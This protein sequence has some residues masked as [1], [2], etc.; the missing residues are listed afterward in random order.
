M[1]LSAIELKIL[2]R[3]LVPKY[4][5]G[6][7]EETAKFNQRGDAVLDRC[8]ECVVTNPAK[9]EGA[10]AGIVGNSEQVI[11]F[12]ESANGAVFAFGETAGRAAALSCRKA[13]AG[14]ISSVTAR[15]RLRIS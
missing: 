6:A 9:S 5:L 8:L 4:S 3:F 10:E 2:I 7:L 12:R 11:A 14:T 13:S 1:I 15:A